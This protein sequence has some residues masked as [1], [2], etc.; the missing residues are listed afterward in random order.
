MS[1]NHTVHNI[2]L[3]SS[4]SSGRQRIIVQSSSCVLI[5]VRSN[6]IERATQL[7]PDQ[8]RVSVV[9]SELIGVPLSLDDQENDDGGGPREC[10]SP[11]LDFS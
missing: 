10:L 7:E 11:S 6:K 8:Y 4:S 1:I 9:F 5:R 2:F 3:Y